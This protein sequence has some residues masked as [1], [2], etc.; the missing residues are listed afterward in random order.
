MDLFFQP[1]SGETFAVV[2]VHDYAVLLESNQ[3]ATKD[4]TFAE[5]SGIVQGLRSSR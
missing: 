4:R 3:E 2:Q 5:Q 1:E